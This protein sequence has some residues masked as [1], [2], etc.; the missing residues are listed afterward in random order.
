MLQRL[1][2][3]AAGIQSGAVAGP[4]SAHAD[5]KRV[6]SISAREGEPENS[7]SHFTH[8]QVFAPTYNATPSHAWQG[9]S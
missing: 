8:L 3:L 5:R 9:L 7:R 2:E 6:A 4:H 1:L